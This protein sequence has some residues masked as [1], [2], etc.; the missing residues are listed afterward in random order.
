MNVNIKIGYL[1]PWETK[2][3]FENGQR[4]NAT[5]FHLFMISFMWISSKN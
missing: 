4:G 3:F 5:Q 1:K 2:N